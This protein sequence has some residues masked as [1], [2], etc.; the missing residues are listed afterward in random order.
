MQL[1]SYQPMKVRGYTLIEILVALTIITLLFSF[2]FIGYRDFSRR[3]ALAGA[4][5]LL[6][7]NLRKAQQNAI[8]GIKPAGLA[9]DNPQTLIGYNFLVLAGGSEYQ[10]QA[11]CTGGT[12]VTD[13]ITLSNS[14]TLTSL[15]S[16]NP[17]LFRILGL[18]TNITNSSTSITLTQSLTGNTVIINI[19]NG[20]DIRQQ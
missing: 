13:D 1:S 8:S 14:L 3:Q 7:G 2:G 18:G 4:A 17:I 5:K 15:P 9:C 6:Q 16:P 11:L 12:I 20:G 10:I 19:G